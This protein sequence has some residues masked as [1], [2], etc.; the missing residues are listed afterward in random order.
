M[1]PW[2]PW[3]QA[4]HRHDACPGS[5]LLAAQF[6]F[7]PLVEPHKNLSF[8]QR[9]TLQTASHFGCIATARRR[10]SLHTVKKHPPSPTSSSDHWEKW[11]NCEN[12][13]KLILC[14]LQPQKNQSVY[15]S[16]GSRYLYTMSYIYHPPSQ[17]N[18]P[19]LHSSVQWKGWWDHS[20]ELKYTSLSAV[21]GSH[22]TPA[23]I[24]L[25]SAQVSW[26]RRQQVQV[27]SSQLCSL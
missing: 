18:F 11:M 1:S 8:N 14:S 20:S 19:P 9:L 5:R 15:F 22:M 25:L 21:Y 13:V 12:E 2:S 6:V 17:S 23:Q 24:P 10:S 3:W 4:D 26:W 27:I 16:T 7:Y